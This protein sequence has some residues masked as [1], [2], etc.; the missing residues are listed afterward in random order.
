MA[1]RIVWSEDAYQDMVQIFSYWNNR[2]KSNLYSRKLNKLFRDTLKSIL[3][4][5]AI[6]RN[7]NVE[8]VKRII[9]RDYFIIYE[10]SESSLTVLRIWDTRQNPNKLKYGVANDY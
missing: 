3:K 8:N 1:K 9:A 2:N 6:G 4:N 10:E 7:T 5:P